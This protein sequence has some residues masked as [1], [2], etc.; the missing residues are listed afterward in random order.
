MYSFSTCWNSHRHTDGR[1]M[2]REIRDLG[3]EY[4]ELSHGIRMSLV[5]GII[6]AVDA[7][8]MKISSLHN[9]C[10]LPVGILHAA[11]NLY[12]FSADEDRDRELALRHTRKTLEFA[13]RMKAAV[14]VL[15][16]GSIEMKDYTGKLCDLLQRVGKDSPKYEKLRAEAVKTREAKKEKYFTR[17]K[18]AL[19]QLLPDAENRGLKLG[20]E[21]RQAL[22]E[23]PLDGDFQNFFQEFPSPSIA[24]WHDAGHAQIKE[25]LGIL[26]HVSFLEPLAPRLAGFHVHDVIPPDRD[27]AAPGTGTIDYAALKPFVKPQHIK[28]FELSPSLQPETVKPGIA[29]VKK[30]WREE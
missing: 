16:L 27:H 20:C 25:N 9:F 28:V 22:E 29:H 18:D 21:N 30:I 10:P 1:A 23:L 19:R 8:E 4:A 14:V 12:Q 5:P 3:F 26:Q 13:T 24:Y 2:L 6:E 17:V 11:P 7:G 15:H